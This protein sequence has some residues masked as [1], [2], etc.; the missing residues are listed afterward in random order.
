MPMVIPKWTAHG[1]ADWDELLVDTADGRLDLN[2]ATAAVL[3]YMPAIGITTLT[4]EN[5]GDA[6]CRIAIHQALLGSFLRDTRTGQ[7][8]FLTKSDVFRHIGVETEGTQESFAHFCDSLLWRAHQQEES[9]L[10]SFVA[11]GRRS[12]LQVLGVPR[13]GGSSAEGE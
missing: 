6:W 7:P 13:N 3:N 5:V 4:R 10:P 11:N 1:V 12:L 2:E 8:F 9:E